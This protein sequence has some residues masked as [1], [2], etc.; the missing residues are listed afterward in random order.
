[1]NN[2]YKWAADTH[3]VFSLGKHKMR[4]TFEGYYWA[5][6]SPII[7]IAH[8]IPADIGSFPA[9]SDLIIDMR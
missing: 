7:G 5:I 3:I 1:M 2:S 9:L 8:Y 4:P 6:P